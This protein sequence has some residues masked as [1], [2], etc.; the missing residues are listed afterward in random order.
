MTQPQALASLCVLRWGKYLRS[1]H[2]LSPRDKEHEYKR[3]LAKKQEWA[4]IGRMPIP[5]D[6]ESEPVSLDHVLRA[7]VTDM[8]NLEPTLQEAYLFVEICGR[9][10]GFTAWGYLAQHSQK[11]LSWFLAESGRG[12]CSS[13]AECAKLILHL[14]G[15]FEPERR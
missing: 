7:M 15:S 1:P 12:A 6:P 2:V 11:P 13:K 8:G 4:T 14:A 9:C 3:L 5:A 10:T